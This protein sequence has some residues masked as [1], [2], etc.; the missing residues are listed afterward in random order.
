MKGKSEVIWATS[1]TQEEFLSL[2]PYTI[3]CSL[4]S[5]FIP[6]NST[7]EYILVGVVWYNASWRNEMHDLT[8]EE[9]TII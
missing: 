6:K 8:L 2:I 1:C 3:F 7:D 5:S 9:Y 4:I